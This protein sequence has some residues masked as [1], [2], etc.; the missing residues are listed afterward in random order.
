MR[1]GERLKLL[2]IAAAALQVIATS[3]RAQGEPYDPWERTNR[4]F[5]AVHMAIDHVL[6]APLAH[7]F[8]V[9]P[10]PL[11]HAVRNV[12]R[13]LGEPVVFANDLLQGHAKTA[14]RTA[15]RFAMNSTIGVAGLLDP[16]E[17]AG[18]PHRDNDFGIT[19][20]KWGAQAGPYLFVPLVGP[21]DLRD[22]LGSAVNILLDPFTWTNYPHKHWV[23]LSIAVV[24]GIDRRYEA[25]TD[26]KTVFDTSTDPYATI[27]SAYTQQRQALVRGGAGIGDLPDFDAPS[28]AAPPPPTNA[29][30][31]PELPPGGDTQ[32]LTPHAAPPPEAPAGAPN[33]A[34][35]S[36]P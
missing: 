8:G 26:L 14:V 32:P 29:P 21:S 23:Q 24:K 30:P 5:F 33:P 25:D 11:R 20:G 9:L 34:G 31:T 15:S 4:G 1:R 16:A 18:I 17:R 19:L 7:L 27:R 13:N 22:G 2:L 12:T 6:L 36:G 35:G 28:D 3:A 10:K